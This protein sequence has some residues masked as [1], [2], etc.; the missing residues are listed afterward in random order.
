[1]P[2]FC[3]ALQVEGRLLVDRMP[4]APLCVKLRRA[5][6]SD[7]ARVADYHDLKIG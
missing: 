2:E 7:A 1:M 6:L 4:T 3:T 5:A